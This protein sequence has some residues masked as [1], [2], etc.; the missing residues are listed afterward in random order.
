VPKDFKTEPDDEQITGLM[1]DAQTMET[2]LKLMMKKYQLPLYRHLRR[3]VNDHEDANDLLQNTFIK[4]YQHID[5]FEGKSRLSTWL[6][7][8]AANE[9]LSFLHSKHR[10]PT[11][12]LELR[13]NFLGGTLKASASVDGDAA[14]AMLED[15][16][17]T[18]PPK[19]KLVFT[20]RYYDELPYDEMS[21][22]L[23]TS[24]G[25]LKASY[26]HAVKKVTLLL[27]EKQTYHE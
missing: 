8:I 27:K 24:E 14:S 6:F 17:D 4:A 13:V 16:L 25:A 23:N 15:I 9:A 1:R 12:S 18:L 7:R 20:L 10:R 11:D 19:Q 2:G 21:L 22:V 3:M 5:R 26:H